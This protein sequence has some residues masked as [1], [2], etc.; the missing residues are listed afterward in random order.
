MIYGNLKI[1]LKFLPMGPLHNNI[2]VHLGT[3]E[4]V[5]SHQAVIWISDY[6]TPECHRAF[7]GHSELMK[8]GW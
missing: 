7:L 1:S 3:D 5:L 2:S 6:Q 8:Y 4:M